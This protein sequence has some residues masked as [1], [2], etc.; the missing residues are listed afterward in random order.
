MEK[1]AIPCLELVQEGDIQEG[2]GE[3]GVGSCTGC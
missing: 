3:M 1:L 2:E